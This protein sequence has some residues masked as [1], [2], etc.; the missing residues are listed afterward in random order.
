MS[1]QIN[2]KVLEDYLNY[3]LVE[4]GAAL[5]TIE[6][7]SRDLH[8]YLACVNSSGSGELG[9]VTEEEVISFI[10]TWKGEGLSTNSVNRALAA[11]RGFYKYLLREQI[12]DYSPVA[13][14]EHAKVWS[15]LPGTLSRAEMEL[16]LSQP[17]RNTSTGLRD[18]AIMELLYATG[19]RVSELIALHLNS[20]NWQVGYLQAIG[21]GD[22][23]RIVPIGQSAYSLLKEYLEQARPLFLK[24]GRSDKIFLT[25]LGGGFTRQGLWKV[26]KQYA[27]RAGLGQKV[28]PHTFRHSFATHLLEGG[29]DL[30]AVQV[31][32][33]HADISTTQIYTHITRERLK[34]VHKR[35]H[36]RG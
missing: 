11:L 32:L 7:Y 28:Y 35:F 25:R 13:D 14:L 21:K 23:S 9:G 12:V 10:V 20:I 3:L 6:S 2:E 8:R 17:A 15:R 33:G 36:P 24:G 29:A 16:L 19:L 31:M 22:K 1:K 27:A 34:E 18:A 5:N 26:I 4:K 30:R